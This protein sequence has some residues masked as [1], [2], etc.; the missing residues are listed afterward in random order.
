MSNKMSEYTGYYYDPDIYV[1][2]N[3]LSGRAATPG[4]MQENVEL[5]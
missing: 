2:I 3:K 5:K 4:W 1:H